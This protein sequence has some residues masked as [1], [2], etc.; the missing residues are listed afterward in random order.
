MTASPPE[1]QRLYVSPLEYVQLSGLSLSTVH[2]YL[3][4]GRIPFEQP[5]GPRSRILI[6]VNA[7][8]QRPSSHDSAEEPSADAPLTSQSNQRPSSGPQPRWMNKR[9]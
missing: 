4:S 8:Q 1:P 2:R 7:L 5:G 3:K 6:P 9:T